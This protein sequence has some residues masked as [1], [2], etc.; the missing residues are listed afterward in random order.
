MNGGGFRFD[1]MW[2]KISLGFCAVGVLGGIVCKNFIFQFL[3][4][5][6]NFRFLSAV[7]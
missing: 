2:T 6:F 5:C 4:T 3:F 1:V 7:L